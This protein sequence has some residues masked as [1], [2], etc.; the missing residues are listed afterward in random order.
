MLTLQHI[1]IT[2]LRNALPASL[3]IL[4]VLAARLA[5][6]QMPGWLSYA[7]WGVVAWRLVCTSVPTAPFGLLPASLPVLGVMGGG[8]GAAGQGLGP[9]AAQAAGGTA[10]TAGAPLPGGASF[11]AGSSGAADAAG[12]G[13][14]G[15]WRL[16]A[17]IWLAVAL[18]LLCWQLISLARLAVR[19]RRARA[20]CPA[21]AVTA[22]AQNSSSPAV[23]RL[24]GLESSFLFGLPRPRIYLPAGLEPAE[25]RMILLHEQAHLRRGDW[26][27]R[28]LAWVLVC[29][30]WFNPLIWLTYCLA[31]R[32]MERCCD[33]AALRLLGPG[34]RQGYARA[35]LSMA[36]GRRVG[37]WAPAF[38]Q[39]GVKGRIRQILRGSA[40]ARW[41]LLCAAAGVAVLCAVLAFAPS[42]KPAVSPADLAGRVYQYEK[43]GFGGDFIIRLEADGCFWYYEGSLSSYIGV[44]SWALEDGILTLR[45]DYQIGFPLVNRFEAA[46]DAL[47]FREEGSSN[48][49]YLKV[50]DGE[51]FFP[52]AELPADPEPP[53]SA[54]ADPADAACGQEAGEKQDPLLTFW[55]KPDETLE[56]LGRTA[57]EV[58]LTA[59]T[60]PAVPDE[61]R[62]AGYE[63]RE[64]TVAAGTPPAGQSWEEM[65]YQYLVQVEYDIRT[66]SEAYH[67]PGDGIAGRGSFE[68]LYRE[69]GVKALGDGEY[70]IV[71]VGTGGGEQYF[72]K[73]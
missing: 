49:I 36:A 41:A 12:P 33:E 55:I 23:F 1:F 53:E 66:A 44:G 37:P 43:D 18:G 42:K 71:S 70:A 21:A 39:S 69:L 38:G 45:D 59:Q 3:C 35:L 19:L 26:L 2:L 16:A 25:E 57:A 65:P 8:A 72:A 58:W 14:Q 62:L 27:V 60:D 17:L 6:R 13:A 28:P 40:P 24:P 61:Q 31:M 4:A 32:D 22:P 56:V 47:I 20:A 73:D 15:L 52:V 5:L 29:A 64:V 48:F 9:G 50:Q 11:A 30:Y 63:I 51:R 68:G 67:A 54:A 46:E 34:A 7:L 10:G